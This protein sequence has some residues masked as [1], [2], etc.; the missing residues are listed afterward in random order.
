MAV[1]IR[2]KRRRPPAEAVRA[3]RL[4]RSGDRVLNRLLKLPPVRNGYTIRRGVRVPMRDGV[5]LLADHYAPDVDMPAG[6]ILMRSPYGRGML[7]SLLF[8]QLY[9]SRGYHILVQSVRGTFGSGGALSPMTTEKD[10]GLDTVEWLR[11]QPWFTGG[12]AMLGV[13]Y[14][15]MA[16]WA[17]L[18]DP[19]HD[20]MAAIAIVGPH[21]ASRISW[22]TGA[23]ALADTL[24][25]SHQ[26]AHQ[27][28][29]SRWQKLW[30]L[31][32]TS[33]ALDTALSAFPLGDAAHALLGDSAPWY[34]AW[35][36]H[37]DKADPYWVP[38]RFDAAM[39]NVDVPVLL[40]TG[41]QDAFLS[42]TLD[43][44]R[45]LHA[46]GVNVALTVG[47]WSHV[48]MLT[49]AIGDVSLETLYW[50]DRYIAKRTD[51][52]ARRRVRAEITNDSWVELPDWPPTTNDQHWYLNCGGSLTEA[53]PDPGDEASEFRYDPTSPTP[54]QGGP[55]LSTAGGYQ[56]D[57]SLVLRDDVLSFTS[58][59]LDAD[60]Y[61][62]GNPTIDLAHSADN[63]YADVFVR[64]SE[65]DSRG[66]SRNVSD[67]Y[68]RLTA[69][70][71]PAR[72][73]LEL[74]PVAHRFRAGS[75]IRVLVAG[76]AHPRFSRN[77]G[78]NESPWAARKLV[79]VTHTVHH[80]AGGNS[81]LTLPITTGRPSSD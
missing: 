34:E 11:R 4:Q 56:E 38:K 65:V 52:P 32:R 37:S 12:F 59:L 75:R 73:H 72:I 6:T 3:S 45:R 41:W 40:I 10:D 67:G 62:M 43:Q 69:S 23:F 47:S 51:T 29:V 1:Q 36:E 79:A 39:E 21:D 8:G 28:E 61:V 46:R 58:L 66:K 17:L 70:A 13:S 60:L 35:I 81:W 9:A 7:S 80:G 14:G 53:E 57:S 2:V 15:A 63:P 71:D 26:V 48:S 49:S 44:Y 78:T 25:W 24:G 77:T 5:D 76:G 22:E 30:A 27:E 64:V 19:P 20:L 55:Y 74:D 33:D 68:R 18:D 31:R 54:V 16:G 42:Q 50:L